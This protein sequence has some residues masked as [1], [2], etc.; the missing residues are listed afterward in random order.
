VLDAFRLKLNDLGYVE[1]RNL[2]LY[3][4]R[5]ND[6][7]ARLPGLASELLSLAPNVI[8]SASDIATLALQQATSSIPII[9]TGSSDPIGSRFVKSLAK[10]NGN[11]TGGS[12]TDAGTV[13]HDANTGSAFRR[14][15]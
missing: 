15:R 4:R 3:V 5:A 13:I 12:G 1:G 2:G 6:D 9:M 11:I 10:P 8:V 7:F 14:L